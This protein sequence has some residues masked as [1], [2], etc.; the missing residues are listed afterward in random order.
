ML[1]TTQALRRKRGLTLR[2]GR[3]PAPMTKERDPNWE[4]LLTKL[5]DINELRE[6]VA[7]AK[8]EAEVDALIR[9]WKYG[10]L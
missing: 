3:M 1:T 2:Y 5:P 4:P 6:Q 7:T 9:A 8:S 10:V